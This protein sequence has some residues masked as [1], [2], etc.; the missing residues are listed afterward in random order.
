MASGEITAP[1]LT[2]KTAAFAAYWKTQPETEQRFIPYPASW[3][4]SGEYADE[5]PQAVAATSNGSAIKLDAPTR[6]P[7][8]F[9]QGE[10]LSRLAMHQQ[11][12]AWPE[13]YWGPAPGKL[14][15]LVPANLLGAANG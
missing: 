13:Q 15:C 1:E 9:T 6:K 10:W 11:G 5:I 7:E 2:A 14:G 4:N 3:L 12:N 8:T